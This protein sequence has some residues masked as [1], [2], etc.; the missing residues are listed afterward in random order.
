[1]TVKLFDEL[2]RLHGKLL[3]AKKLYDKAFTEFVLEGG[4]IGELNRG[5]SRALYRANRK[6]EEL[7]DDYDNYLNLLER[8]DHRGRPLNPEYEARL[9]WRPHWD[10]PDYENLFDEID[11]KGA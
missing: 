3:L 4:D 1:M 5:G 6:V 11:E 8:S 9:V 2:G 7:K 10:E